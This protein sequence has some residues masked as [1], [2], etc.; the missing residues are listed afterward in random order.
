MTY[1]SVF[2]HHWTRY[3]NTETICAV[4]IASFNC[5]GTLLSMQI[6]S[7]KVEALENEQS[8]Y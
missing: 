1:Y 8:I 3:S 5:F 4:Q 2:I 7:S 6:D